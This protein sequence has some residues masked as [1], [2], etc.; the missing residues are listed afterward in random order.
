MRLNADTT[1]VGQRVV[2][3]PYRHEHVPRYHTWMQSPE[4]QA[5]AAELTAS[6]PL[7][8]EEEYA[9]QA[10]WAHDP[11]KLTYI[12]LDPARPPAPEQETWP[13][14]GRAGAMAGDVNLFL[15][16]PDDRLA[17]EVEIMVAEPESRRKGMA[18]EALRLF[19]A[20]VVR[21][22]GVTRFIA[23]IGED[24]APSL[25]L[26]EGQLGFKEVRR[27]QVFKE[28]HLELSV[29]GHVATQMAALADEL[30]LHSYD[31]A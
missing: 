20:Y 25:A 13:P 8:L 18:C 15:N 28:V 27:V 23:K 7:S 31:S 4:L 1:I 16:D 9:M 14:G 21:E 10:A 3:V 5:R 26:F 2:L 11:D 12:L 6:E 30:Q 17:G 29:Q 24:N 22:L 19:M